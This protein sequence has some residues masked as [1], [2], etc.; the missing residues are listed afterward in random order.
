MSDAHARHAVHQDVDV[1]VENLV[2]HG[3]EE[4]TMRHLVLREKD[5]PRLPPARPYL[6]AV[7]SAAADHTAS[8]HGCETLADFI[9][10]ARLVREAERHRQ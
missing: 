6:M 7:F 3:T 4:E 2:R 10:L 1:C 9:C 8:T 5:I